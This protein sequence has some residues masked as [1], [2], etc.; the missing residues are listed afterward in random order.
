MNRVV[1]AFILSLPSAAALASADG[2]WRCKA[3]GDIPIGILDIS[4]NAYD[5][6][7]VKNSA[8]DPKPGDPGTGSGRLS[9]DGPRLKPIDGPL[10]SRYQ[11]TLAYCGAAEGCSGDEIIDVENASGALMRCWRP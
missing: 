10:L 2:E 8:W 5:F 6:T 11:S 3:N 9:I 7:V 4:G 1:L